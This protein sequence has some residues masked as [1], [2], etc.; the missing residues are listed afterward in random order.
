M[1]S[2]SIYYLIF[3]FEF[4]L[5]EHIQFF[6]L[7]TELHQVINRTTWKLFRGKLADK[8]K[9]RMEETGKHIF[10]TLSSKTNVVE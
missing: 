1:V 2:F 9:D 4:G 10:I 8:V 5:N 7:S 3:Y 6:L